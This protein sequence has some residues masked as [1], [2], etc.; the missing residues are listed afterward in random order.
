MIVTGFVV[1]RRILIDAGLGFPCQAMAF[2]S[3]LTTTVYLIA[4]D[5][6]ATNFF[7]TFRCVPPTSNVTHRPAR[8][9][10]VRPPPASLVH[11][12]LPMFYLQPKYS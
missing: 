10:A 5:C 3:M 11:S 12:R 4:F 9:V 2:A 1:F 8:G 6:R 7:V